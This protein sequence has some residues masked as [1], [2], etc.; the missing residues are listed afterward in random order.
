MVDEKK[1]LKGE[2]VAP[3]G[4]SSGKTETLDEEERAGGPKVAVSGGEEVNGTSKDGELKNDENNNISNGQVVDRRE[5]GAGPS[6]EAK[7]DVVVETASQ[8]PNGPLEPEKMSQTMKI[9][10]VLPRNSV[11]RTTNGYSY[12]DCSRLPNAVHQEVNFIGIVVDWEKPRRTK[13]PDVM[14]NLKLAD[15]SIQKEG[16]AIELRVFAPDHHQLPHVKRR[17]D[18]IRLHRVRVSSFTKR[19]GEEHVTTY[20]L[21]ASMGRYNKFKKQCSFCLFDG[22]AEGKS[23]EEMFEP[24]QISSKTFHFDLMEAFAIKMIRD[25][26]EN[27][28]WKDFGPFAENDSITYRRQIKSVFTRTDK[29]HFWDLIGLV[30]DLE[31]VVM[32]E[33]TIVW[34]WDGTNAPPYPPQF[35][36]LK[37]ETDDQIPTLEQIETRNI[38]ESMRR[39]Q[40]PLEVRQLAIYCNICLALFTLLLWKWSRQKVDRMYFFLVQKLCC[41]PPSFGT[42]IPVVFSAQIEYPEKGTWIRLRNCGFQVIE[43]QLQGYFTPKTR[44]APWNGELRLLMQA[45]MTE[46][47]APTQGFPPINYGDIIS[48]TFHNIRPVTPIREV[49]W[50]VAE[51]TKR[52]EG[53]QLKP[54]DMLCKRFHLKARVMC[55]W[56]SKDDIKNLCIPVNTLPEEIVKSEV[57]EG[58]EYTFAARLELEDPTGSMEVDLFG[59]EASYFFCEVSPPVNLHDEGNQINLENLLSA[60]RRMHGYTGIPNITGTWLDMSVLLYWPLVE[61]SLQPK[62]RVIDTKLNINV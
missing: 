57:E 13:G 39:R 21:V 49:L 12:V 5:A 7:Q 24:Y 17:G 4:E 18:I 55:F 45:A 44:W 9:P 20:Q 1:S 40:L 3:E 6:V 38:L 16:S 52:L 41:K 11:R 2:G 59:K 25:D 32:S 62:F 35:T 36:S 50:Y 10:L 60:I 58:A 14:C 26:I 23:P 33:Y 53:A 61:G 8:Q 34:V 30:V 19:Q 15:F 37:E 43:G 54:S 48:E 31:K 46:A 42:I 47:E 27:G 22:S 28:F 56:P 29:F 51:E